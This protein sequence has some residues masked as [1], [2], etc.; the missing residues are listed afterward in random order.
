MKN[1]IVI[2]AGG[3]GR[4]VAVHIERINE[5]EPQWNLVGY[6]DE[7]ATETPEGYP[8]LGNLEHFLTMDRSNYY[9]IA[10]ANSK[11]R[12]KIAAAC[13]AAG[14]KA[15]TLIYPNVKLGPLVE[16]GEGSFLGREVSL[17]NN[18][19]IGKH[20]IIQSKGVIGH[21]TAVGSYTSFMTDALI[22]GESVIGAHCYFGLRCTMINRVKTTDYCTFGACACVVKDAMEAGTYVGVPAKLIKPLAK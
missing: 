1:I 10:I 21:D 9:F 17:M 12:E 3:F 22:G 11:A 18:V 6:I 2:G 20:C 7:E 15:A 8:I 4:E 14:F 16:I 5:V 13:E 19:K